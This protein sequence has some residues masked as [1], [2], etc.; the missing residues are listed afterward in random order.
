MHPE[1]LIGQLLDGVCDTFSRICSP[2]MLSH[3]PA[4]APPKAG[5][6]AARM[7]IWAG[8]RG[9]GTERWGCRCLGRNSS[10]KPWSRSVL[11][12]CSLD[13]NISI[14]WEFVRN[15]NSQVQPWPTEPNTGSRAQHSVLTS[16]PY[17]SHAHSR[18]RGTHLNCL[19][20]LGCL[21]KWWGVARGLRQERA[22]GKWATWKV[23]RLGRDTAWK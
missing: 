22:W 4:F 14:C 2:L 18:L 9:K 10:Q 6:W 5:L 23:G 11:K 20:E 21:L 12:V 17:G 1:W 16:P 3:S 7:G 19:K 13:H 15:A 8:C